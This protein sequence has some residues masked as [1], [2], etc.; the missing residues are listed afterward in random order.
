[1]V[2]GVDVQSLEYY[3][4]KANHECYVHAL[5]FSMGV[6]CVFSAKVSVDILK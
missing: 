3:E 4:P 5:V 6:F 1:M 2:A